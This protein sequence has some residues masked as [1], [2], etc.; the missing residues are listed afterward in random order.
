M[1]TSKVDL[2]SFVSTTD[3]LTSGNLIIGGG[4]KTINIS[5]FIPKTSSMTWDISSDISLPSMKAI[6]NYIIS[7]GYASGTVTSVG[8][9]AP[10]GFSVSGSPIS[11]SGT[12]ALSFADGYSLP[13]IAN[14]TIWTNKQDALTF[15]SYPKYTSTNPVQSKG[16]T[17]YIASRGENL[18]TNGTCLLGDNYNFTSLTY[19][20]SDTY[21]AGGCFT[22]T[23]ASTSKNSNEFIPVD[24]NQ[25]YKLSYYIKSESATATYYDFLHMYDIDKNEIFARNVMFITGSTTTLAQDLNNGDTIVYLTDA[26]G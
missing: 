7:K 2:N 23:G 1:E 22:Y 12:L 4:N 20:G 17:T 21:Y 3:T 18:V 8:L 10:T 9:S 6:S 15:D 13:T 19:S 11:T 24:V 26:S 25:K 5:S 16:I 14:Q